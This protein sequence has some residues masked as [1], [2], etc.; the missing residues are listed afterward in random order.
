MPFFLTFPPGF[1]STLDANNCLQLVSSSKTNVI[2]AAYDRLR[3]ESGMIFMLFQYTITYKI[4]IYENVNLFML[5]I[6]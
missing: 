3:Y 5:V 2:Q 4:K 1:F 6:L